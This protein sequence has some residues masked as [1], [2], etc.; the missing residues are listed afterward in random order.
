[1]HDSTCD[2]AAPKELPMKP[3]PIALILGTLI[4][5]H[6]SACS[7]VIWVDDNAQTIPTA[8]DPDSQTP[9]TDSLK[10][11][12]AGD[13][14][15]LSNDA[16]H[17]PLTARPINF[18]IAQDTSA[19][20]EDETL[21]MQS[22][23]NEFAARLQAFG[24]DPRIIL[25]SADSNAKSGICVDSPLG[26]GT[27]PEDSNPTGYLHINQAV[28]SKDALTKIL[29]THDLWKDA[30]HPNGLTAFMVVS[31]DDADK[32]SEAFLTDLSN[33]VPPIEEFVFYAIAASSTKAD[34]C[35]VSEETAC[36]LNAVKEGTV[37]KTLVDTTNG[38]FEDLC[39]QDESGSLERIAQDAAEKTC[40][41]GS[42]VKK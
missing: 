25:I 26:A 31:D 30:I 16:E 20:M 11:V 13:F 27:C 22:L 9:T 19:G 14:S 8:S 23:L 15:C 38:L 24:M 42:V 33:L 3:T 34:A 40:D 41:Q 32:P 17:T 21:A 29:A 10:P 12:D 5:E 36:C 2:G 6:L 35:A 7:A 28:G 39:L 37:Y 18:I 4:A 1:M